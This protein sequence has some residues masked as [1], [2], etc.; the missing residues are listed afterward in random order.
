MSERVKN[1]LAEGEATGHAH[2][3]V[4]D[5]DVLIEDNIRSFKIENATD[6]T[7]EEHHTINLPADDYCSGIT[8]EYDHFAKKAREVVD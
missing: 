2:R 3:L 5:V 6:L 7:H 4:G 8:L 1:I